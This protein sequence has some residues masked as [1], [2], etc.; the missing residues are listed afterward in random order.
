M[1]ISRHRPRLAKLLAKPEIRPATTF[2]GHRRSVSWL[3]SALVAAGFAAGSTGFAQYTA[4]GQPYSAPYSPGATPVFT[5]AAPSQ[6]ADQSDEQL[7]TIGRLLEQQGRYA[8]AQRIYT[9]LERRRLSGGQAPAQG[10]SSP[11][12]HPG[13]YQSTSSYQA[14]ANYPAG[15]G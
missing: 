2:F 5:K 4:A 11:Y 14:P 8:Q 9:E 7:L 13:Q 1:E 15:A 10:P 3:A 6:S 12:T